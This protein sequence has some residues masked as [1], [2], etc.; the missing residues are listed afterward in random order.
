[1]D[2]QLCSNV[3][4]SIETGSEIAEHADVNEDGGVDVL[5]VQEIVNTIL[6][7]P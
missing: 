1:M 7:Q 4:L 6:L 2:V 5:D 3:I